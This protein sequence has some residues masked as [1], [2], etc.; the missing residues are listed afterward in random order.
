MISRRVGT[1]V[2]GPLVVLVAGCSVSASS[3]SV[4]KSVRSSSHSSDSSSS[5]SPG[6]AEEAYR[7]DVSDY[8]S[9][10]V[11][12][13]ATSDLAGFRADLSRLAREHGI[14]NWEENLVTYTAI[15]AGL[16]SARVSNAQLMAYKRSLSGGDAKKAEAIQQGYDS[17]R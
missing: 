2:A 12:S 11:K 10:F 15:G 3:W 13:A 17:A 16:G 1:S 4:S 8:T 5:S 14:T 7:E 9:A 6:A